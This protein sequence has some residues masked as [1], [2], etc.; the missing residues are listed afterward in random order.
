MQSS[1]SQQ[2]RQG[3]S[4]TCPPRCL[5]KPWRVVKRPRT[6][7][8][9][10]PRRNQYTSATTNLAVRVFANS[11]PCR[12]LRRRHGK[13][14]WEPFHPPKPLSGVVA[15]SAGSPPSIDRGQHY[16]I[17]RQIS[18]QAIHDIGTPETKK[19]PLDVMASQRRTR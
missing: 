17:P 5:R 2:A 13:A 16:R 9:G 4:S 7:K 10:D 3:E 8:S 19:R 14:S 18:R 12:C 15:I 11:S 6:D 1:R